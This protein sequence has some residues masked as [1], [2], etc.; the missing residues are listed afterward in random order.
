MHLLEEN[1]ADAM[2]IIKQVL[3]QR[4]RKKHHG[5][6]EDQDEDLNALLTTSLNLWTLYI[7]ME[8]NLGSLETLK[9]A[10]RKTIDLKIVT[11]QLLLNYTDYL[12]SNKYYEE[13]F[14]Q[15]EKALELFSWPS[16]Y[17]VWVRYLQ[18]FIE[19]YQDQRIERTRDMFEK[20][21]V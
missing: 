16:L 15:Y 9:Q 20:A 10:Y 5:Y 4:A 6:K 14:R 17:N 12:I 13:A 11:P 8:M 3:F 21:L 7:D 2:K 1:Y 19:R 18:E